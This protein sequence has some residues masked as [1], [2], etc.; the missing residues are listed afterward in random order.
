M[1]LINEA[2]KR[3]ESDKLRNSSPYFNNLTLL[4]PEGDDVPA[5]ARPTF[6][7][8]RGPRRPTSRLLVLA[9]VATACFAA[10]YSWGRSTGQVGPASASGKATQ[11]VEKPLTHAQ[12]KA[13]AERSAPDPSL[14]RHNTDSQAHANA[15]AKAGAN[16]SIAGGNDEDAFTAAMRKLQQARQKDQADEPSD[17]AEAGPR[18]AD[19][20]TPP[21][22]APAE[23]S[24]PPSAP[25]SA[26]PAAPPPPAPPAG[27]AP[28]KPAPEPSDTLDV[29]KLRVTAIMR[30]PE[31]N[32][33]LINGGLYREGQTIQGAL[34]VTIG[35]Y[36]VELTANGKRFTIRI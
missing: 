12:M 22:T 31:G 32:V 3:S 24:E 29:S 17:Q 16:G 25:S 10:W 14:N 1:S 33:A 21:A 18:Q 27:T 36:E 11:E 26:V 19:G 8:P 30:G 4:M 23:A 28:A 34:I 13:A 6:E 5:P 7:E 2:I 20:A 9:L 15:G 35:Q